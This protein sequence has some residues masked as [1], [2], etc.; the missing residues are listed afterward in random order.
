MVKKRISNIKVD[1]TNAYYT[2][3]TGG[4]MGIGRAIACECAGRNMNLLLVSLPEPE[5][6]TTAEEIRRKFE[7]TVHTLGIDLTEKDAP[8]KVY[9]WC[10][11]NHYQINILVNN[12][13]RAGTAIFEDSTFEYND[14]RIQLNIR[15]LV[16]LTYLFLKDL[17]ALDCS[18]ILNISSFSAFFSIP[19]KSVY[20]ASKAFVYRFSRA[21]NAELKNT[22]VSVTVVC[23]NGVKTN[24]DTY[25][26]INTHGFLSRYVILS[27]E[28]VAS[29]TI[30]GMLKDKI[31]VIPGLF[32][33]ILLMISKIIPPGIAEKRTAKIFTKELI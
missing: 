10:K 3:I 18:Y 22:S 15:A 33:K 29:I 23:P 5:L 21:L 13:G 30:N 16:C 25:K 4:S 20:C 12:A 19:Y 14:I 8:E 11:I 6:E 7:I 32:N 26:R 1:Q 27:V 2:L 31:V 9:N 17:K 28:E 24:P